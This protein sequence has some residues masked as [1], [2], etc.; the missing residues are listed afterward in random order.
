MA[1]WSEMRKPRRVKSTQQFG[2]TDAPRIWAYCA[3]EISVE[4]SRLTPTG[5]QLGRGKRDGKR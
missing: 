1:S 5:K 3:E 2:A 4:R